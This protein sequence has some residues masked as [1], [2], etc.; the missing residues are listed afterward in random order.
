MTATDTES[1]V[2]PGLDIAGLERYLPTVLTDYDPA[3]GLT[4]RLLTGGRSNLT[5][6]LTQSS[7]RQWVLRRPPL[8]HLTPTAHDMGR[9]FRTL[10]QL[11]GTGFPAP[12]PRALC[13]DHSVIGVTFLLYDYVAG[14]IIGDAATAGGLPEAEADRLSGELIRTLAR[15]HAIAPPAPEAG[16]S[17]S[18]TGYLQRQLARWTDQ[19]QRNQTRELPAF[20]QLGRWLADQIGRLAS[21]YPSTFVHGDYRLD[22][23]ILDPS[24]YQV[25]AV[26]DWE[27]S[28][29]GDPLMDL[30]LL[31]AYWEQPGD[32]LRRRV[33]VARNLTVTQG[34]WSRDRLLSEYLAATGVPAE[35][36]DACL[37]LTCLKLAAILEGVH[38]RHQAGEALDELSAGM[39]DAAPAMLEMGLLVA[40]GHGLAGL[41]G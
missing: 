13:T 29:F 2:V 41:A 17:R 19:W 15:L 8:G 28:T 21:D 14:C 3:A 26:L 18:S 5:C 25:R 30:A 22:N 33:N 4:A 10:S 23:L 38:Y 16:R 7:G 31:L 27:M 9:E 11:A 39:A 32:R 24:S 36:L 34:F 40:D 12:R 35:H 1:P 37:G 6:L 20:G